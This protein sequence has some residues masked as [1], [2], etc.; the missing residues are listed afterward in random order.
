M[1]LQAFGMGR[2]EICMSVEDIYKALGRGIPIAD[3]IDRIF[4]DAQVL[5]VLADKHRRTM[6][7]NFNDHYRQYY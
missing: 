2:R 4:R 3:V 1:G 5:R 6:D 7:W